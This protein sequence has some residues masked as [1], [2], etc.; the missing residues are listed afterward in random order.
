MAFSSYNVTPSAN[1][2]I[3]GQSIA[4][5]T[6]AP[7][8]INL[9]VRTLMSDGKLL[10]DQVAGINL[11]LYAPLASPAFTGQPTVSARGAI[12]HHNNPANSSG[13]IF[14]QAVGSPAPAMQNGDL[15]L[16]Y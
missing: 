10:S 6:T 14:I 1:L 8:T 11:S 5:G 15:L 13:R 2:T 3:A 16:E 9:A 4:E 7:G 12:L